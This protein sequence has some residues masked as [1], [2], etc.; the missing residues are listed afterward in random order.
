MKT[1][2]QFM[3]N[4]T[5]K[6]Y[7]AIPQKVQDV[8]INRIRTLDTIKKSNEKF[9]KSTNFNLPLPLAKKT[10]TVKTV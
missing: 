2:K 1:F 9:R 7:D 8:H 4:I 5:P 3:E 10:N 6:M